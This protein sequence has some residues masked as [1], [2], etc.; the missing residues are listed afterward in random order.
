MDQM[1]AEKA[2][3]VLADLE[4]KHG[5]SAPPCSVFEAVDVTSEE[6]YY[7]MG[8]WPT[9]E[10]AVSALRARETNAPGEHDD[11]GM[12]AEIRERK[13]GILD[14]S[15]TGKMVWKFVWEK[16]YDASDDTY[17]WRVTET[18]NDQ[19]LPHRREPKS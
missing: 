11:D 16:K 2:D 17:E 9:L 19:A 15:E 8:I 6:S 7:T 14:W 3:D 4:A 13:T 18:P 1:N 5:S 12:T 10:A